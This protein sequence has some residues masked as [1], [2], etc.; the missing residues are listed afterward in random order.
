VVLGA[1]LLQQYALWLGCDKHVAMCVFVITSVVPVVALGA[2]NQCSCPVVGASVASHEQWEVA[3][4]QYELLCGGFVFMW[5]CSRD[6]ASL[7]EILLII[8]CVEVRLHCWV[9]S[10]CDICGA[11]RMLFKVSNMS[12]TCNGAGIVHL[13]RLSTCAILRHG[14]LLVLQWP[15]GVAVQ[16]LESCTVHATKYWSSVV[17]SGQHESSNIGPTTQGVGPP[18]GGQASVCCLSQMSRK[19]NM[20]ILL[21]LRSTGCCCYRP[22][23]LHR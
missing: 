10:C 22:P 18:G 12:Q 13:C 16:G 9:M 21:D 23:P 1:P 5:C 19:A 7:L 3:V 20:S 15:I 17:N 11:I 8:G 4:L 6:S 2:L 14:I